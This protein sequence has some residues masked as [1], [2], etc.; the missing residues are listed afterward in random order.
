L[1]MLGELNPF[2]VFFFTLLYADSG[3]NKPI[4]LLRKL[5]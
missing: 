1:I 2:R 4:V 5:F 3:G